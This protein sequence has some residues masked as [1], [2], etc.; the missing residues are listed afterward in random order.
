M[1]IF[2]LCMIVVFILTGCIGENYDFS[3][4]AINLSSDS[5]IKSEELAEANIDWR[6]V[7]NNPIEKEIKDIIALAKKQQPMYFNTVE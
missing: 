7:G 3:P 5:N 4:P 1:K 6:G 2:K